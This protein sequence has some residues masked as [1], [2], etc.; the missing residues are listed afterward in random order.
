[1]EKSSLPHSQPVMRNRMYPV[2]ALN[3]AV[4]NQTQPTRFLKKY[5]ADMGFH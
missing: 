3:A 1:M 5:F 2:P 4:K